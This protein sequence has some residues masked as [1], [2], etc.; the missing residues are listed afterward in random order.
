MNQYD[1]IL[2]GT[3]QATG[4]ILPKLLALGK[5][6]AVVEG[7]RVG[8]TCV[9]WGCAPTK[10]LVASSRVARVI[11]DA[12]RFGIRSEEPR[13]DYGRVM[14]RVNEIRRGS[15]DGFR[16]WLE[17]ATDFYAGWGSF[18]DPRTVRIGDT[19]IRG[20]QILI[21][22]GTLSRK[23]DL[24]GLDSVP[25]LDNRSL[26]DLE[27][28][29][30]HLVILG[31]SYIGMEF[32][33]AYRRLGSRVSVLESSDRLVPREDPDFSGAVRE[34]LE[35]EGVECLLDTRAAFVRPSSRGGIELEYRRDGA[36][37][38]VEG[39]HLLVAVGRAPNTDGLD[40]DK[41]GVRRDSRG[42]IEV[43]DQCRTSVPHIFALGDVNGRGAFTHT[44]VHDGQVYLSAL[45][46]GS[47]TLKDRV[48]IYSL[49]TDPPL[50]R[51]GASESD[52][53]SRGT[54]YRRAV[55]RMSEVPRAREKGETRG[56]VKILVD[57][58]DDRLL[59]AGI[60]GVGGDE[61]IG[62]LALAIRAKLP[63]T[64]LT[65]TILPHPTL[66]EMIPW[67]F[68]NLEAVEP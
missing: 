31:G 36:A 8:G 39:S 50:A 54:G 27:E 17:K 1:V 3:G 44:S 6:I 2:V 15:S 40:L 59:G 47:R 32:A 66:S 62:M 65:D 37:E 55:L 20:E 43:D 23:P 26:L 35:A 9:N 21:H 51:V 46:G 41:A 67:M 16:A 38:T 13:I 12:E 5:R 49:Y 63:Y 33:Q 48:P 4:T 60:L 53:K 52:L 11:R 19:R 42:Y 22:T 24:P 61:A 29:P 18:E 57:D 64:A 58:E 34:L 28:L 56:F 10:T 68:D 30:E 25:W 7:G 45:E 14:E